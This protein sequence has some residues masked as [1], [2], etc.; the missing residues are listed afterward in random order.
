MDDEYRMTFSEF[1]KQI[2]EDLILNSPEM[3]EENWQDMPLAFNTENSLGL[4]YL[5]IYERDG[6]INLD[7]GTGEE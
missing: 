4:H 2:M 5:S 1:I 6:V 7:V 3:K